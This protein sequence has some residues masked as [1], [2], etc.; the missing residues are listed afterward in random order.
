MSHVSS[1]GEETGAFDSCLV[2]SEQDTK[3]LKSGL[4]HNAAC[5]LGENLGD[6]F[7][8]KRGDGDGIAL[9][10]KVG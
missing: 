10:S 5:M 9:S 3:I 8:Y 2:M 6:D 1:K 4:S 7:L